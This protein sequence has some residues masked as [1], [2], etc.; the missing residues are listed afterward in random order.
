[1]AP[2]GDMSTGGP[3]ASSDPGSIFVAPLGWAKMPRYCIP[4]TLGGWS[5]CISMKPAKTTEPAAAA[6]LD[7]IRRTSTSLAATNL[8]GAA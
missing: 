8:A 5:P 1:M 4:L 7:P 3:E 2:T 6:T